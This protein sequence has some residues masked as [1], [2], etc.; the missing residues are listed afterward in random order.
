MRRVWLVILTLG[1][2][3]L[4]CATTRESTE[5]SERMRVAQFVE[6]F[7]RAVARGDGVVVY[8]ML[9]QDVQA[10]MSRESFVAWFESHRSLFDDEVQRMKDA[11]DATSPDIHVVRAD[12]PCGEMTFVPLETWKLSEVPRS[13]AADTGDSRRMALIRAMQTPQFI[14]LLN[15]YAARHPE[16]DG[17]SQRRVRRALQYDAISPDRVDFWGHLAMVRLGEKDQITLTCKDQGWKL[18]RC[19]SLP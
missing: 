12:D 11:L 6:S 14:E 7:D 18:E 4:A 5:M 10:R 15:D 8:D 9:G 3:G 19:D 17:A 16:W 2:A 13:G 1:C